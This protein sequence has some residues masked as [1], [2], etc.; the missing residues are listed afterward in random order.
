[1]TFGLGTFAADDGMPFAGLVVDGR[2]TDL[3][4]A[5]GRNVSV[6]A[7][8]YDLD[9]V[10]SQLDDLGGEGG[11][12]PVAELAVLPP[13]HPPGAFLLAA[14][15]YRRHVI[16]M[17]TS[18]AVLAGLDAAE[19]EAEAERAMDERAENGI[20]LVFAG[21]PGAVIGAYDDVVIPGDSGIRHDWELELAVVIGRFARCVPKEAALDYVAGYTILNDISTRDRMHRTDLRNTDF[22]ATKMRPTFKPI[23]PWI[24]PAAFVDDPQDL[25]MTLSVNG[26]VRQDESTA[27]MIFPI[28]RLIEHAS[29][30]TDLRPGDIIATGSPAGNAGHHGGIWLKPGDVMDGAIE[31]LGALSNRC[32][33]ATVRPH[34]PDVGAAFATREG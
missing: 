2:V 21:W 22:V 18:N 6:L 23:G 30:M 1:M 5:F 20:P 15:N 16:E 27:D 13:I 26:E 28:A 24:T 19:A 34:G 10:F 14:A 3:R 32:V 7:L 17:R 29:G 8:I 25:R 12:I 11:D 33:A 31:G 9:R 4:E